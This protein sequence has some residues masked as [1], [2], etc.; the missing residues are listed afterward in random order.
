MKLPRRNF[1][2]GI[3]ATGGLLLLIA[4]ATASDVGLSLAATMLGSAVAAVAFFNLLFP[5]SL[6]FSL[7][8]ANSIAVYMSIF[9]F[10]TESNFAGVS[11]AAQHAGLLLPLAGFML[12]AYLRR[13]AIR[14]IV[15]ER[16]PA[17]PGDM[18][19][20]AL[21]LLPVVG[22]AAVTFGVPSFASSA[23]AV[24]AAFLGAMA[25]VAVLVAATAQQV[26]IFLLD[27]GQL[28][29]EFFQRIERLVLPV[30]AFLTF[31]SLIVVAFAAIYKIVDTAVPGPHFRML[32]EDRAVSFADAFY[33]SVVTL[34][35]VGYGDILPVSQ[36]VRLI[37]V[38]EV[39]FGVTLLLVGLSEI[40]SYSREVQARRRSDD[41]ADARDKDD[42]K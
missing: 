40:M 37:A 22:V 19:T 17:R 34:S 8:L 24:D 6:F 26:A 7:A 2:V 21:W 18:R 11:A 1:A 27:A 39:V 36:A 13:D 14:E 9:L 23:V 32:G 30:Y 35:T 5:G 25:A 20:A 15:T 4:A 28:F 42:A 38:V 29:E 12:G 3:G 41:R 33:F 10:L 31:Y 16:R